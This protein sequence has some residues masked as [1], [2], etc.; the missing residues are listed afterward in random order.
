MGQSSWNGGGGGA[1]GAGG[2]SSNAGWTNNVLSNNNTSGFESALH[3]PAASNT[4]LAPPDSSMAIQP[5]SAKQSSPTATAAL[6][7]E[8][9]FHLPSGVLD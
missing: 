4:W 2:G 6:G 7:D 1:G 3:A 9:G 5:S 8:D